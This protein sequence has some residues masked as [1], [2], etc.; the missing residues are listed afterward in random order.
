M[1]EKG[2][3]VLHSESVDV[4]LRRGKSLD[5][6]SREIRDPVRRTAVVA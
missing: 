3:A 1:G 5:K 4:L 6:A 2:I